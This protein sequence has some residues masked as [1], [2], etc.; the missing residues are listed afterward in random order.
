MQGGSHHRRG[1]PP[2][3]EAG[4]PLEWIA[5]WAAVIAGGWLADRVGVPSSYL[6]SSILAGIA[7]ALVRPGRLNLPPQAFRVGQAVTGVTIGLLVSTSTFQGLGLKWIAVVLISI[8]TLATTIAAGIVLGR[9]TGLDR[10]TASLGLVAGGA[11]GIVA[12]A[13]ELGADDRIVSFMQYL[14]VLVVTLTSTLLVPIAF[15]IHASGGGATSGSFLGTAVGWGVTVAVTL[16]GLAIAG[17]V[18]LPAATLLLPLFAAAALAIA[19]VAAEPDMPGILRD[20]GFALIGVGIGLSFERDTVRRIAQL[21]VPVA[22]SIAGLMAV[23]AVL[24]WLLELTAGVSFLDGYL[25]TT[26]GGLYAVLPVAYG[27]GANTTFVLTVQTL[28][29]LMMIVAAPVVVR[30]LLTRA[31]TPEPAVRS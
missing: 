19:G 31:R 18:R 4:R 8:A 7:W 25:A 30:W 21:L 28:R 22:A 27:S 17:R 14:R 15:G 29:L 1:R 23:C 9:A 10:A 3:S 12:M 5:L 24:G 6:F 2:A 11:S 26:P 13:D 16:G 20:V